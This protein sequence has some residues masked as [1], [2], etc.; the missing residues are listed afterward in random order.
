MIMTKIN[1]ARP[2][3]ID[4]V[5]VVYFSIK[6]QIITSIMKTENVYLKTINN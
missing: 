1:K 5:Y 4:V 6:Y 3:N 2:K